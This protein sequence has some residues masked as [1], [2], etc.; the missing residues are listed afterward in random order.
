[1]TE[2]EVRKLQLL[3]KSSGVSV[4]D[5]IRQAIARSEPRSAV[6]ESLPLLFARELLDA[7][8]RARRR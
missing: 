7:R 6:A 5:Y 8:A 1:M 4:A 2:D 3:A